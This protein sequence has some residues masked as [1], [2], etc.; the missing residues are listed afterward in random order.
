MTGS[1]LFD[2]S[3]Y[4]QVREFYATAAQAYFLNPVG[5]APTYERADKFYVSSSGLG[6][7]YRDECTTISLNYLSSPIETASG[8]RER[9]RTFLLRIELRTLG[10][11]NFRQN[12]STTTT[13]DGIATAR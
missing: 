4:L 7:G 9:N 10:E 6:F 5:T 2:L 3:H 13:A 12:L 11:A 1:V 8:L